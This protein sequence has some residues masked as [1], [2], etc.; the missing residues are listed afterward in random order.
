MYSY[1]QGFLLKAKAPITLY[2][3]P[4]GDIF[5]LINGS[6]T[7][8][9][10]RL[11]GG[12]IDYKVTSEKELWIQVNAVSPGWFRFLVDQVEMKKRD[13]TVSLSREQQLQ[14]LEDIVRAQYPAQTA[15]VETVVDVAES[16]VNIVGG[17]LKNLPWIVLGVGGV[18]IY[19]KYGD[20]IK[21]AFSS[22]KPSGV[23]GINQSKKTKKVIH[24]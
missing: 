6:I 8:E 5:P 19:V 11:L 1:L 22:K 7:V 13:S 15:I 16:G 17:I 24:I 10:G 14:I 3:K 4:P 20:D 18:I 2:S 12:V 21:K 9:A 23:S